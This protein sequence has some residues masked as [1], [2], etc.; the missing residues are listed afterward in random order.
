MWEEKSEKRSA[1]TS[2]LNNY[3]N[4][5]NTYSPKAYFKKSLPEVHSAAEISLG[6]K[7]NKPT[8]HPTNKKT[9]KNNVSKLLCQGP[10]LNCPSTALVTWQCQEHTTCVSKEEDI[11]NTERAGT[12]SLSATQFLQLP[13]CAIWCDVHQ[14]GG[15]AV[16]PSDITLAHSPTPW[17][18]QRCKNIPQWMCYLRL[19][20]MRFLSVPEN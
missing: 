9:S 6:K 7:T 11:S 16:P 13:V 3:F 1:N 20:L 12:D 8:N 2:K 15:K 5:S 18:H 19:W 10:V 4:T 17:R 14:K